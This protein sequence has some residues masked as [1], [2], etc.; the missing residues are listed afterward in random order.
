M[1]VNCGQLFIAPATPMP[2]PA[3]HRLHGLLCLPAIPLLQAFVLFLHVL[4]GGLLPYRQVGDNRVESVC[5]TT[6]LAVCILLASFEV[7]AGVWHTCTFTLLMC[8]CVAL[9]SV[10][11]AVLSGRPGRG[12][13]ADS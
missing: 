9:W 11:P 2:A 6:M 5:L 13:G 12:G 10:R 8:S 3:A 4:H 7:R 1:L